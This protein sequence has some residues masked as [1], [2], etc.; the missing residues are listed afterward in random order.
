MILTSAFAVNILG[1]VAFVAAGAALFVLRPPRRGILGFAA[2]AALI[3]TQ[4]AL[5]N[6]GSAFGATALVSLS[7]PFSAVAP[8]ALMWGAAQYTNRSWWWALP[9]AAPAAAGAVLLVASPSLMIASDGALADAGWFFWLMPIFIAT[10]LAAALLVVHHSRVALSELK[11]ETILLLFALLPYL[12]YTTVVNLVYF[13]TFSA[14][15]AVVTRGWIVTFSFA[16]LGVLW[17]CAKLFLMRDRLARGVAAA[18]LGVAAVGLAQSLMFPGLVL[19]GGLLRILAALALGYGLAKFGVFGTD[20][21]LKMT[22]S[23]GALLGVFAA[24][25]FVVDQLAQFFVSEAFGA[26]AGIVAAVVLLPAFAMLKKIAEGLANRAMPHTTP[27]EAYFSSR[28]LV[29]Y[30]AAYESSA[31]D[32]TVTPK[33]AH[34]LATLARELHLS[35]EESAAVAREFHAT[36]A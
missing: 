29:I 33:E 24:V 8:I 27:T 26:L 16:G 17:V 11:Q 32:G 36:S 30:R 4:Q 13:G 21:K 5:G 1:G 28:K 12:A 9:F 20:L 15:S 10:A 2:Y 23:R 7:W 31:R 3:G 14:Y 25:F 18:T 22:L 35:H 19:F 6:L 34:L